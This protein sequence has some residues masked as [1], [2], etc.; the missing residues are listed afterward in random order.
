VV[1]LALVV[2]TLVSAAYLTLTRWPGRHYTVLSDSIAWFGSAIIGLMVLRAANLPRVA[3][4]AAG[5]FFLPLQ[6]GWL[7]LFSLDYVCRVFGDCL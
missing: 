2:P 4:L 5:V 7:L 3:F 1:A 6:L